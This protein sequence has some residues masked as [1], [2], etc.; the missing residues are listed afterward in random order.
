MFTRNRSFSRFEQEVFGKMAEME[1]LDADRCS[2]CSGEDCI[3][4]EVYQDRQLWD[5]PEEMQLRCE[6]DLGVDWDDEFYG[7]WDEPMSDER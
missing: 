5:T 6:E 7:A 3:A 4:C 1:R 2:R